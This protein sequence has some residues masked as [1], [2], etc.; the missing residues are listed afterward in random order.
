[1]TTAPVLE[2][3]GGGTRASGT[4]GPTAMTELP[5]EVRLMGL[6]AALVVS[7]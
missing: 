2:G 6:R 4:D 1:M 5:G 7:G 3:R